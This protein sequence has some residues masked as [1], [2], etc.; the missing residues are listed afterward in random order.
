MHVRHSAKLSASN[1]QHDEWTDAEF[2]EMAMSQALRGMEDEPP[3]YTQA[4][5]K[6]RW[7]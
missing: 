5:L 1:S 7:R 2:G 4:D 3:L 6:E